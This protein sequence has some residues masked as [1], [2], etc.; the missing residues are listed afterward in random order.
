MHR[1]NLPIGGFIRQSLIDY[2][3]NIAS[4]IFLSG[5]N[6]RCYYCHNPQLVL[7]RLIKNNSPISVNEIMDWI[8]KNADLLDAVVITG[9][10]PTLHP[11]LPDFLRILKRLSLSIKLD[12]NGTNSRM[13]EYLIGKRLIDYVAMDIK[14]PLRLEKYREI[15]GTTF[16]EQQLQEIKKSV[17]LLINGGV[18][19]EFRTTL[20]ASLSIADIREIIAAI[21]GSYYLQLPNENGRKILCPSRKVNTTIDVSR[22]IDLAKAKQQVKVEV[23]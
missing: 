17:D 1:L 13:I 3:G 20:N 19:Y 23:R 11:S 14:A 8:E 9:G 18:D 12:T 16:T 21:K 2:P 10:E 4:V 15:C 7:P 6:M 5:C 22:A